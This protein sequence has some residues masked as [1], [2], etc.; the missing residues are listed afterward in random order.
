MPQA[1]P[2]AWARG[3]PSRSTVALVPDLLDMCWVFLQWCMYDIT[4]SVYTCMARP[5]SEPSCYVSHTHSAK[6]T[7][8]SSKNECPEKERL[9]HHSLTISRNCLI[10]VYYLVSLSLGAYPEE[11]FSFY[12]SLTF[13][14]SSDIPEVCK[15]SLLSFM[16]AIVKL[17][18]K[19]GQLP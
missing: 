2:E 16:W 6:K 5:S 8:A 1:C 15:V 4:S 11:C 19:V 13:L 18:I 3:G 12:V 9:K 10:N 17:L 14:W 7:S